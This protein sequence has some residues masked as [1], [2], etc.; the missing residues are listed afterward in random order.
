MHYLKPFFYKLPQ[1]ILASFQGFNWL[2]HVLA[3]AS[4]FVLVILGFDQYYF[5]HTRSALLYSIFI[6]TALIGFLVPIF[7]PLSLY[8][9]GRLKED[10]KILSLGYAL[11]QSTFVAWSISSVYKTMTGRAHP[12]LFLAPNTLLTDITH[13]FNFGFFQNGIF[14][15]W[16]SSHTAVAFAIA[17]TAIVLYP[18][19]KM[20]IGAILYAFYIGIGVSMTIH[21][22]TD[23]LAGAIIG[24]V[25][26]VVV[27]TAFQAREVLLNKE[28]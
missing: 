13:E 27:A 15:G 22:F 6:P 25:I 21:W 28:S 18:N 23:F 7:I 4:T 5:E 12:D 19:I 17:T 16:P 14:W 24:T 11:A 26:G 3:I 2:W 8:I 9:V 1:N 10:K 20:K